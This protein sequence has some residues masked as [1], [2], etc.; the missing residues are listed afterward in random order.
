MI[1]IIAMDDWDLVVIEDLKESLKSA[2]ESH[3][4]DDDIYLY[5][6]DLTDYIEWRE[7][8]EKNDSI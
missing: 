6:A 8:E 5:I 1:G 2:Q 3:R 7:E 4:E